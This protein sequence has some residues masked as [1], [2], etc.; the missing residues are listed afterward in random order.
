MD[1]EQAVRIFVP[2]SDVDSVEQLMSL[3]RA[4]FIPAESL[5]HCAN[6]N[7][8][9]VAIDGI[10]VLHFLE[11]VEIATQSRLAETV[12]E[13]LDGRSKQLELLDD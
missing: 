12:P 8:Y 7:G 2:V 10:M 5:T 13:W 3:K 6:R 11:L 1:G 9:E 4:G